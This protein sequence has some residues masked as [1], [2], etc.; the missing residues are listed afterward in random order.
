MSGERITDCGD[1]GC[2]ECDVCRYLNF[3]EWVGSVG[4]PGGSTIE[5]NEAIEARLRAKGINI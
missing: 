2:E 4:K 1:D 5:R 3:L